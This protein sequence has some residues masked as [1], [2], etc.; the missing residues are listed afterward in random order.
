MIDYV[1]GDSSCWCWQQDKQAHGIVETLFEKKTKLAR[2]AI[3]T[4]C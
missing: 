2:S 1:L 4:F 3:R